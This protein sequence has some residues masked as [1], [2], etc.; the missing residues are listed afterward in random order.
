MISPTRRTSR[1]LSVVVGAG[2]LL[3]A[4]SA[5]R[6]RRRCLATPH[7]PT[8]DSPEAAAAAAGERV[9]PFLEPAASIGI[10]DAGRGRD[11][12][13]RQRVLAGGQHPV[14]PADHDRLRGR[15]RRPRLGADDAQLRPG[16][17]AEARAQRCNRRSTAAPTTSLSRARAS[18]SSATGPRSG[19][20]R[21]HPRHRPVQHRRDRRRGERHLRQHRQPGVQ[22]GLVPAARRPDHL[23]LGR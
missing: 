23:R 1:R 9:A 10:E 19:E 14:D 22:P 21:R 7:R 15:H 11:P 8:P 13:R 16:R 18:T 4:A 3:L 5:T 20:E 12:D 2:A 6:R 17:P